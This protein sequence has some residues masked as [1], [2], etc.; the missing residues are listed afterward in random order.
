[1]CIR[2]RQR[3]NQFFDDF[4]YVKWNYN[5]PNNNG[6]NEHFAMM[7]SSASPYV[8]DTN[9]GYNARHIVEFSSVVSPTPSPYDTYLGEFNGHTYFYENSTQNWQNSKTQAENAGGYLFVP[10]SKE[11]FDFVAGQ[12][13]A[14][15]ANTWFHIGVYQDL[16]RSDYSEN[17]GGWI[18]LNGKRVNTQIQEP[19]TI[20]ANGQELS[21]IH[22]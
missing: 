3:P 17:H 21:L 19:F 9:S 2:D 1:M 6:N 10:N 4:N 18:G 13:N 12:A 7:H 14:A 15:L 5:E 8:N 16:N 20:L 22:I 11:E